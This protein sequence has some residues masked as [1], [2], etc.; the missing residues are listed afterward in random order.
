MARN[1]GQ[2]EMKE[3]VCDYFKSGA[4]SITNKNRT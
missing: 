2:P 4:E 1:S 3:F